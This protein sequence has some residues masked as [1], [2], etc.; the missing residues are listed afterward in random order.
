[1]TTVEE[2]VAPAGYPGR[3]AGPALEQVAGAREYVER[4]LERV[5]PAADGSPARLHRAMREAVLPGGK[6]VRPLLVMLVAEACAPGRARRDLVGRLAAAVELVHCASLVHDDLPAFDDAAV[7]RGLPTCHAAHGEPAAILAGDALLALAFEVLGDG[8]DDPRAA[9]RLVRLLA[10]GTGTRRGIIGGQALELEPDASVDDYHARKTAALFRCAAA[11]A[12]LAA[13]E[14]DQSLRWAR[15]GEL[16]GEVL[17]LRDDLEDCTGNAGEVGKPV[18]RDRDLGRPNA[19]L[20]SSPADVLS[21]KAE[22]MREAERLL[23]E[24]PAG[25]ALRLLLVAAGGGHV[26]RRHASAA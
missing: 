22:R 13:G 21:G 3:H 5:L 6:R 1:M 2:Q 17:Q 14:P 15:F 9:L 20:R 18:G 26:E 24:G 8:A 4:W 11:G 12:A 25:D 19:V 23:P 16:L 10:E 7:R